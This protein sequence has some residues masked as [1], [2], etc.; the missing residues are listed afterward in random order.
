MNIPQGFNK[1][2][3]RDETGQN[4]MR[5]ITREITQIVVILDVCRGILLLLTT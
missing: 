2:D 5:E 4:R 3:R 1:K